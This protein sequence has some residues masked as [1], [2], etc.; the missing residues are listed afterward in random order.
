MIYAGINS[1]KIGSFVIRSDKTSKK[2]ARGF[3]GNVRVLRRSLWIR[4]GCRAFIR[5]AF[6]AYHKCLV[7]RHTYVLVAMVCSGWPTTTTSICKSS[8]IHSLH[9][10]GRSQQACASLQRTRS[11]HS[12]QSCG[13]STVR[14][15]TTTSVCKIF[16]RSVI[17]LI[18]ATLKLV[19]NQVVSHRVMK[20]FMCLTHLIILFFY[21]K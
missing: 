8:P 4:V 14:P 19:D 12:T 17:N 15:T 2:K 7:A 3:G 6:N 1:L 13:S 11:V 18:N 20:V 21:V 16:N 10:G 9:S 5:F